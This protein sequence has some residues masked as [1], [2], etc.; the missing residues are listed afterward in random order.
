[1]NI[2]SV[3]GSAVLNVVLC[4]Q[5]RFHPEQELQGAC[6]SQ[7]GASRESARVEFVM[8][9]NENRHFILDG[10]PELPETEKE[11]GISRCLKIPDPGMRI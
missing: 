4:R 7:R 11:E 1:M 8:S 6:Q 5:A 2:Q 3:V 10:Y 9:L